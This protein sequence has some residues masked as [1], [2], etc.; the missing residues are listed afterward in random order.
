MNN[1]TGQPLDRIDG[2]LKVTGD[3][4]YAAEFPEARLAHAVL[5]V[6]PI[7][8]AQ[9]ALGIGDEQRGPDRRLQAIEA[10]A[11]RRIG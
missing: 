2:I 10:K 1:L 11:F 9:G 8:R 6:L 4:R 5:V 7:E 3:A